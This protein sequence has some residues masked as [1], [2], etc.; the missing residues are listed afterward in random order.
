MA[1]LSSKWLVIGLGKTEMPE[2]LRSSFL[3]V[4]EDLDF[5]ELI[6]EIRETEEKMMKA[7]QGTRKKPVRVRTRRKP[8]K[9][10]A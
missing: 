5:E 1:S 9:K 3:Q 6:Q 8:L 2:E 10:I 7:V 4:E